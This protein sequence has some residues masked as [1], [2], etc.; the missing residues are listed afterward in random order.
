M[1]VPEQ[2]LQTNKPDLRIDRDKMRRVLLE[3]RE[4][5]QA[6][7]ENVP[8]NT[9]D[10]TSH[11]AL[12]QYEEEFW[13]EFLKKNNK[14][15]TVIFGGI[16]PIFV[17]YKTNEK[18]YIDRFY[19]NESGEAGRNLVDSDDEGARGDL[20]KK[21]FAPNVDFVANVDGAA[22]WRQ[23]VN[24]MGYGSTQKSFE[25]D[26]LHEQMKG[27]KLDIELTNRKEQVDARG[28]KA[29]K[30]IEKFNVNSNRIIESMGLNQ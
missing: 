1:F 3:Y 30:I 15:Q 29:Q 13:T 2:N 21:T 26:K 28:K 11:S 17:P 16:N 27:C 24:E 4:V 20:K 9:T 7:E 14:Y 23:G 8:V 6:F 5:R 19:G 10:E 22:G 25:L 18:K 12:R